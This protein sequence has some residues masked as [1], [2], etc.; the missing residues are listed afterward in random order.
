MLKFLYYIMSKTLENFI[1]NNKFDLGKF[2]Y[3][4]SLNYKTWKQN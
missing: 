1:K 4:C 3:S 2:Y